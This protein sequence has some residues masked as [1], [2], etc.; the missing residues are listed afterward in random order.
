MQE[1]E[2][3]IP[4]GHHPDLD[5]ADDVAL[6]GSP[7][8]TAANAALLALSRAARSF[9]IYDASNN[10]IR[11]FLEILQEKMQAALEFGPLALA[12]RPF[13]MVL[14][15]EVVY[16]ERRRDRSLAFR[17]FRDGVR[18]LVLQPGIPWG[19]LLKLLEVLSIRY[20]G[21]RQQ[22]DDIVTLLWK[23]GF[24]HVEIEAIEGFVPDEEGGEGGDGGEGPSAPALPEGHAQIELAEMPAD[25]DQPFPDFQPAPRPLIWRAPDE[26]ALA[27]IAQACSSSS[28]PGDALRLVYELI[29][30][31]GD[32]RDPTTWAEIRPLVEEVRDFFLADGQVGNLVVLLDLLDQ[33][34]PE[35]AKIR[36]SVVSEAA[37]R[38]IVHRA[39]R[40]EAEAPAELHELVQRM[41][42][43]RLGVLVQI[44]L[45]EEAEVSRKIAQQLLLPYLEGRANELV[46]QMRTARPEGVRA[47]MRVLQEA[48][49]AQAVVAALEQVAHPDLDVVFEV[50]RILERAPAS[51]EVS[52]A[53]LQLLVHPVEELRYRAIRALVERKEP[54]LGAAF[55]RRLEQQRPALSDT[56]AEWLGIGLGTVTPRVALPQFQRWI[57]PSSLLERAGYE[58][59]GFKHHI[60][61]AIAGLGQM[62]GAEADTL[63][64]AAVERATDELRTFGRQTQVRR[65]RLFPE[66]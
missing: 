29:L 3:E 47:L 8:A 54:R 62:P 42:G 33:A 56:E 26:A 44:L 27:T 46:L 1:T 59:P 37:L 39:S 50:T 23:A 30:L 7:Q 2:P 9:L 63:L 32:P 13:E 66:G 15:R 64:K 16:V 25:W 34:G 49:P 61:A 6:S 12:V 24:T 48:A 40:A 5:D 60:R 51:P 31:A 28:L 17:L 11:H 10:A 41:S 14:D 52:G 55:V 38:R 36:A 21:V 58:R 43:D 20:T 19:E 57:T 65:R 53:L 18:R 22:E 35:L 4:L 45:T